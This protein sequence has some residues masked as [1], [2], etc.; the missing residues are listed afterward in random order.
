MPL[1]KLPDPEEDANQSSSK[2]QEDK[3]SDLALMT[4]RTDE[5]L[6]NSSHI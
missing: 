3:W 6:N 1:D 2:E 4:S 5:Q